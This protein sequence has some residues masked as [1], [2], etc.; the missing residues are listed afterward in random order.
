[1]LTKE[2]FSIFNDTH[3]IPRVLHSRQHTHTFFWPCVPSPEDFILY[4]YSSGELMWISHSLVFN[5]LVPTIMI[6]TTSQCGFLDPNVYPAWVCWILVLYSI[7]FIILGLFLVIISSSK[8]PFFL[9]DNS[10]LTFTMPYLV[11]FSF[12]PLLI[13]TRFFH[14]YFL[15]FCWCLSPHTT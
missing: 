14:G 12:F 6:V 8:F 10:L 7:A 2:F 9:R 4:F 1:M 13:A 11:L 15:K 3:T 5:N